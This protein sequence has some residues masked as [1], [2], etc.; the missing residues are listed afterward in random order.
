MRI[1]YLLVIQI[2]DKYFRIS[3]PIHLPFILGPN[4]GVILNTLTSHQQPVWFMYVLYHMKYTA[5]DFQVLFDFS[6][7]L[8]YPLLDLKRRWQK[9]HL[10]ELLIKQI[11]KLCTLLVHFSKSYYHVFF[12]VFF[13]TN[14]FSFNSRKQRAPECVEFLSNILNM[15]FL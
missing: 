14:L 6:Y 7:I 4:R 3:C 5:C 12:F 10:E 11:F 13:Q 9:Y 2:D 1:L 8:T 15:L